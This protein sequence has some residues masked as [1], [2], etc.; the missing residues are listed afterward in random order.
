MH[1]KSIISGINKVAYFKE[2]R[3]GNIQ[4]VAT[5]Q[6]AQHVLSVLRNKRRE[7]GL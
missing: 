5:L 3:S 4:K 2:K 6:K 1:F 7:L